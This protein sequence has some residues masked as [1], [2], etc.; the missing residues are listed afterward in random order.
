MQQDKKIHGD[1]ITLTLIR[2]IGEGFT[3]EIPLEKL[4]EYI[5]TE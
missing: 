5:R 1:S 3:T 2:R 4:P